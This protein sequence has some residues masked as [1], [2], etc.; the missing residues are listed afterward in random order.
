[1]KKIICALSLV[2]T[3]AFTQT[4]LC[5]TEFYGMV[6]LDLAGNDGA[7]IC[8]YKQSADGTWKKVNSGASM[9]AKLVTTS[10][11]KREYYSFLTQKNNIRL[12]VPQDRG[13]ELPVSITWNMESPF[14]PELNTGYATQFSTQC[15]LRSDAPPCQAVEFKRPPNAP[16][17]H[18]LLLGCL[19]DNFEDFWGKAP[20]LTLVSPDR[21][22]FMVFTASTKKSWR[23]CGHGT[24]SANKDAIVTDYLLPRLNS[25]W[26]VVETYSNT[27]G[28]ELLNQL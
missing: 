7:K 19:K 15:F 17:N 24:I 18:E 14:G 9:P 12:S 3:L 6:Q 2:P 28:L 23:A 1:M 16:I 4:Y 11:E 22:N 27:Q 20:T 21:Q 26:K 8:Q 13:E 10:G 25:N 5:P